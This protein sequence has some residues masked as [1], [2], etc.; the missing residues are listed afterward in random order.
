MS[1]YDIAGA[2]TAQPI[3]RPSHRGLFGSFLAAL[4]RPN[5]DDACETDIVA[6][7]NAEKHRR[8]EQGYLLDIGI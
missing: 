4:R 5:I 2:Y 6:D 7:A 1:L 3:E 8:R